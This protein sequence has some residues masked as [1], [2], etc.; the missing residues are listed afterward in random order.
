M[1]AQSRGAGL[2]LTRETEG[3]LNH[4]FKVTMRICNNL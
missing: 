4:N 2:D 3:A 1:T